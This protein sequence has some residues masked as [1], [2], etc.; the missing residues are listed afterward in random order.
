MQ[1]RISPRGSIQDI[2]LLFLLS[3]QQIRSV[4]RHEPYVFI[5]LVEAVAT[6]DKIEHLN[7]QH[8]TMRSS[9]SASSQL[10]CVMLRSFTTNANF[11]STSLTLDSV[12]VRFVFLL[13]MFIPFGG[14]VCR[15]LLVS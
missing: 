13:K 11:I 9:F 3:L 7:H 8:S 15:S 14:L 1:R 6:P 2:L 12:A 10:V 5:A 4:S